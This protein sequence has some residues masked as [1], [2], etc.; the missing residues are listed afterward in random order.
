MMALEQ[1]ALAL[2]FHP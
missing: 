2:S 1:M